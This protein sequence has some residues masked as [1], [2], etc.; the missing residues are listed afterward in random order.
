MAEHAAETEIVPTVQPARSLFYVVA[1]ALGAVLIGFGLSYAVSAAVESG[2]AAFGFGAA[3]G[4]IVLLAALATWR[5]EWFVLALLAGRPLLDT[6]TEPES[7]AR[8]R[9]GATRFP[10]DPATAIVLLFI[11]FSLAWLFAQRRAGTWHRTSMTTRALVAFSMIAAIGAPLAWDSAVAVVAVAKIVGSVLMFVVLEQLLTGRVDRARVV[12]IA[13][14]ASTIPPLAAGLWQMFM[15]VEVPVEPTLTGRIRGTFLHPNSFA[16][17]LAFVIALGVVLLPL[18]RGAARHA[19][20][21][22]VA[23]GC[24]ELIATGG[25]SAWAGVVVGLVIA[26]RRVATRLVA[27]IIVAVAVVVV[28]VPSVS[29]RIADLNAQEYVDA[30]G[31]SFAWRVAYWERLLPLAQSEPLLGIGLDGARALP[32]E[33]LNRSDI[34]G[35]RPPHNVWVQAVVETGFAGLAALVAVA[36]CFAA[37]LRRRLRSAAPGLEHQLA[38]AAVAVAVVALVQSPVE[39]LLIQ[40]FVWWYLAACATFGLSSAVRPSHEGVQ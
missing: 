10:I 23:L 19:V 32:P 14:F 34:F 3:M 33:V 36:V 30:P 25:R 20:L 28:A 17:Y 5:F 6:L 26:L 15:G 18:L 24:V 8:Q 27:V 12:V 22:I 40:P 21:A 29:G 16:T 11:G 4:L 31:N 38:V 1:V 13:V 35:G 2:S 37:D 9:V 39:N 7:I